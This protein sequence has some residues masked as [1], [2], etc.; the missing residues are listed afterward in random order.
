MSAFHLPLRASLLLTAATLA[1]AAA[2]AQEVYELDTITVTAAGVQTDTL[3]APASVTVIT[4]EQLEQG[5]VTDLTEALRGVPGVSSAGASDG[6]NIFLRGLPSEYTLILVD[7]KRQDTRQSR[8]NASGGVDQYYMPPASAIER[9]EIVRG[10]MSSLYGSDAMGGVI[11]IITKPVAETWAGSLTVEALKPQQSE[12]SSE[13]QLSFYLSGPL[14]ADKLGLQLWGRRLVRGES[15]RDGGRSDR[16]LDDLTAKL[17]WTPAVGHELALQFGKTDIWTDPRM[18]TRRSTSLSYEGELGAWDVTAS[19]SEE[20]AQRTTTG[21]DRAPEVTNTILEAKASRSFDWRG[22]HRFTFGAQVAEN[23]LSDQNPGL[24]DGLD[25]SF[26]N[27]QSALY[28]EDIW[29]LSDRFELTLGARFTDDERFGGKLTPRVYAL[30][31]LTPN[32]Y[33]SGG[34]SAG[35][36]TPELRQF[37]EDYYSTTNRGAGVIPGNPDLM[38]EESL[39]YE[40]GLR[41]ENT[42]SSIT[43]TAFYT[44]FENQIDS[45]DTGTTIDVDGT[46]YELYEYYNVGKARVQGVELAGSHRVTPDLKLSG[47]YTWTESE[48]LTGDLAGQ[49]LSRT[50]E[51]QASLRVDWQAPNPDLNLWAAANYFGESVSVSSSSRGNVINAYDAYTTLDIGADW[52]I[53][54]NVVLKT[55]IFNA[56]NEDINNDEQDSTQNGRAFWMALTT[57]F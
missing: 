15:G 57:E 21:S 11:N 8:T 37:V 42:V 25:Y 29:K 49:P 44:D 31:E 3:T 47:S 30:Y 46:S 17:T 16:E 18:N 28:A 50:P 4:G 2:T 40:L 35:Y 33:L 13:Q 1:P 41:F 53:A 52:R 43:A 34:I 9:I 5:A 56:T 38:P 54:E 32:L 20:V 14:V 10:P 22:E 12:D 23:A 7:G 27:R 55:A 36:R 51:H 26:T 24:G 6:Q 45:R 48:R 39:S 19:L